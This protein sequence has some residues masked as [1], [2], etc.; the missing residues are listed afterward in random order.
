LCVFSSRKIQIYFWRFR[1]GNI[2]LLT[3]RFFDMAKFLF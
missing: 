2:V 3:N 1:W